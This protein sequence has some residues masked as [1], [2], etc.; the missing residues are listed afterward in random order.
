MI[1]HDAVGAPGS[2]GGS[3]DAVD[4][5]VQAAEFESALRAMGWQTERS[6]VGTD[7]TRVAA[8]ARRVDLVVNLVE[9]LGGRGALIHVVPALIETLGVPMTGCPADAVFTT[10]NKLVS[11]RLL[12][13]AG[14]ATPDWVEDGDATP[15]EGRW[16]IKSVWEHASIGLGADA[17]VDAAEADVAFEVRARAPRL[18]GRAFAERFVDGRE[19]NISM[20]EREGR[21][22]VLPPAEIE[23]KGFGPERPRIVGYAAKWDVGSF[24]Y[25]NT[26]RRFGVAP[27]D[28]GLVAGLCERSAACWS[29]MGLSGYAR[30][31]YR[32]DAAGRPWVLEVNTNPCL[33]PDAGFMAAA[34]QA[35]LSRDEVVGLIV[36]A[37]LRKRGMP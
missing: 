20:I 17:V 4:A 21:C 33:S 18:G 25:E 27:S 31:D 9:S 10:S 23:F 32:V 19:F 26:P 1:L 36:S 6:E 35:G 8:Q 7:L 3:A 12:R 34:D 14:L 30:V 16:I 28:A 15:G 2:A 11:K 13:G 29:A 22:V 24:E 37:A 5:L